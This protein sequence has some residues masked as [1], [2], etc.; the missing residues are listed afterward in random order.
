[1]SYYKW[2]MSENYHFLFLKMSLMRLK[3]ELRFGIDGFPFESDSRVESRSDSKKSEVVLQFDELFVDSIAVDASWKLYSH[4]DRLR[5]WAAIGYIDVGD[6]CWKR[7]MLAIT[8]RYWWPILFIKNQHEEKAINICHQHL[9]TATIIKS[10]TQSCH[11]HNCSQ[12]LQ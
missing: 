12:G 8:S 1:M 11:Q 10:S 6:G 4:S 5:L 9:K 7:F 2:Q 3:D